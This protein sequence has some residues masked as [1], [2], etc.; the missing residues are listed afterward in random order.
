[1]FINTGIL[2]S[3]LCRCP[4]SGIL[5]SHKKDLLIYT[6]TWMN[7][8]ITPGSERTRTK[9]NT[10]CT[11][12]IYITS[13][14]CNFIYNDRSVPVR[15]WEEGTKRWHKERLWAHALVLHG[16][17]VLP[18]WE[19]W[20]GCFRD[21]PSAGSGRAPAEVH[22]PL[23]GPPRRLFALVAEVFFRSRSQTRA[24]AGFPRG[25]LSACVAFRPRDVATTVVAGEVCQSLVKRRSGVE[26]RLPLQKWRLVSRSIYCPRHPTLNLQ[27]PQLSIFQRC[28]VTDGS[29]PCG[30]HSVV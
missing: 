15:E 29:Y 25:L 17:F 9:T 20:G 10:Y 6:T 30:E 14:K 2:N 12:S 16:P 5:L 22:A 11:V 1:M 13:G 21:G 7:V 4:N 8:K 23:G 3:V 28:M 27:R 18:A 24:R 26:E 19:G